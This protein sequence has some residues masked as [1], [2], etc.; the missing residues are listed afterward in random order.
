MVKMKRKAETTD[1]KMRG[2]SPVRELSETRKGSGT[3]TR[4]AKLQSAAETLT[5][6]SASKTLE[7]KPAD[8][9]KVKRRTEPEERQ[10]IDLRSVAREPKARKK[11]RSRKDIV[12]YIDSRFIEEKR[13]RVEFDVRRL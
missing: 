1:D 4:K 9:R 11:P 10:A 7:L 8:K 13:W 6:K 12:G 2:R 3:R 5:L